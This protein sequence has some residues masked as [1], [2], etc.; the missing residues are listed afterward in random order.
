MLSLPAAGVFSGCSAWAVHFGGFSYPAP[1][2]RSTGSAADQVAVAL[3]TV[4]SSQVRMSQPM[5]PALAGRSLTEPPGKSGPSVVHPGDEAAGWELSPTADAQQPGGRLPIASPEKDQN[6]K[7]S[8]STRYLS[9]SHHFKNQ[10][11]ESCTGSSVG[12]I[13]TLIGERIKLHA[14]TDIWD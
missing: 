8:V 9:L 1:M 5:S 6:S 10:N 13:C 14:K 4:L 11:L 7:L 2:L 12:T 3:S